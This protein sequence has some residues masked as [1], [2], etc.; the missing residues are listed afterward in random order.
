MSDGS[1]KFFSVARL[2]EPGSLLSHF[3][4]KETQFGEP[5]HQISILGAV[6]Q[7]LGGQDIVCFF[8]QHLFDLGFVLFEQVLDFVFEGADFIFGIV[9]AILLGE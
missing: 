1:Q 6:G 3:D 9:D 8:L 4:Q 5:S 7:G 2:A